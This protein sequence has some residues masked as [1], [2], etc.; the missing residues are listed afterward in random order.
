MNRLQNLQPNKVFKYFEEICSIPHGSG[1][2]DKISKYCIKFAEEHNLKY[3]CDDLKNV[4]I[5][6]PGT[7]GYENSDTIILQGHLDMV[8]QKTND[9]DIDFENDGLDILTEGDFVFANN[10]TLGAD[11]GIAV[12]MIMA[13][14]DSNDIPH[15]PIEALFTTDEETGMF[16]ASAFDISLLKGRKLINL[17]SEEMNF[18]TVS[19][20]GGC[21]LDIKMPFEKEQFCGKRLTIT[22]GGLQ[23]GHSGVEIDKGRINA[24]ILMGRI[25]CHLNKNSDFGIISIN[26]G[27][28]SNAITPHCIAEIVCKNP[29]ETKSMLDNYFK[30][31]K[32]EISKREENCYLVVSFEDDGVFEILNTSSRDKLLF[33]LSITPNGIIDMS[34]EIPNLVETSLNLGI[35][36]T[37]ASSINMIY[38]LRSNKNSALSYLEEKMSSFAEYNDCRY[39]I[40]GRYLPWEFK[41]GSPLQTLYINAFEKHFGYKPE[42]IAIHAGLECAVFASK[43]NDLDCIS[44]GPDIFDVHTVKEKLSISSTKEMFNLLCD[45]LCNCK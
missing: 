3:I 41:E 38:T 9:S 6:K 26:G 32:S 28:K 42:I 10:T 21:N 20:A 29:D 2:M 31:I 36:E 17:D 18:V 13:I 1:N 27:T 5:Y 34:A 33:M 12:A 7:K 24:N 40:S 30:I 15:P 16:G 45:T 39:E 44:I 14:L 4:L 25:L 35:L 11:N 19:C 43:T 22:L 37:S 8:C 23:G